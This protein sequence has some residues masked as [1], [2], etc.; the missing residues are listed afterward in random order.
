LK[1][2]NELNS[3]IEPWK[4]LKHPFYQAWEKGELPEVALQA[5]AKEYGAFIA[6]LPNGWKT[7][8]DSETAHEEVEHAELWDQFAKSLDTEVST[9]VLPAI[10]QLVASSDQLFEERASTMGAMFAFEV[11]Q[12]ETATTKLKGLRDHFSL[13][14]SAEEYFIEHTNNQHEAEKL[15]VL[16]QSL[17]AEDMDKALEACEG[18]SQALWNA[19][20][21]IYDTYC[22]Q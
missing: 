11:Q 5:Y 17:S 22:V 14:E 3:R 6:T 18:M 12:P 16:M 1:I 19:L 20:T 15:L 13:P 7:L 21:D 4:L 8:G 9:P 2:K 10:K